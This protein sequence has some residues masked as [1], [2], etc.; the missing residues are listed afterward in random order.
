MDG[1]QAVSQLA[2]CA[3]RGSGVL[4]TIDQAADR[5]QPSDLQASQCGQ[6]GQRTLELIGLESRLAR[7]AVDVDLEVDRQRPPTA[8]VVSEG[9]QAG[10]ELDRVDRLDDVEEL[11]RAGC[12]VRLEV[13]DHVPASLRHIGRL[14]QGLLDAVLAE[15]GHPGG[16]CGTQPLGRY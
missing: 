8:G 7:V 10:R 11:H 1:A 2:Q 9:R 6:R 12:F 13:T 16:E 4:G 15:R 14:P 5:H 3:V